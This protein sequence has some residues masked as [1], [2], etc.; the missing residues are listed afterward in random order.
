MA[1]PATEAAAPSASER[2]RGDLAGPA[3]GAGMQTLA[4]GVAAGIPAWLGGGTDI[5]SYLGGPRR[6]RDMRSYLGGQ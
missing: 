1:E 6:P 4:A 5:P 2:D 3:A